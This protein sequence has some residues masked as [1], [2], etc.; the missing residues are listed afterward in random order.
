MPVPALPRGGATKPRG[1]GYIHASA[2]SL[3]GYAP[4]ALMSGRLHGRMR[5]WIRALIISR[6]KYAVRR[7]GAAV[8]ALVALP[9]LVLASSTP[10]L[11]VE[12][13]ATLRAAPPLAESNKTAD[14]LKRYQAAS[15]LTHR[16][17]M[18]G[19]AE[20][21]PL[22]VE[23]RHIGLLT[24]FAGSYSGAST[25][26]LEALALR[27]LAGDPEVALRLVVMLRRLRSPELFDALLV[28]LLAG[29][30]DCDALLV[31]AAGAELERGAA[32]VEPKLARLLPTLHPAFGHRV[33]KRLADSQYSA[34]EKPLLELLR[35]A[36][37]DGRI[38]VV[39]L[40]EQIVRFPSDAALNAVARKLIEIAALAEDKTPP[41]PG[42]QFSMRIEDIPQDGLLC[43][44]EMLR[45]PL[46]LGDARSR[47]VAELIRVLQLAYPEATLD[48]GL[49]GAEA[50]AKLSPAERKSFEAMLA[51]RV[52]IEALARDLTPENLVHWLLQRPD[53]RM[54]KRFIARGIDINRPT[55]L[56]LRPLVAAAQ[57]ID[58]EGVAL[59]LAAGADPNLANAEPDSEGN[60]ALMELSRHGASQNFLIEAGTRTMRL[61]LEHKADVQA[62]NRDGA[63]ALHFAASQ[64]P[65]LAT[66]LLAAGAPVAVAARNGSTP[67]HR[68][69]EGRQ[70]ELA[71]TLLDRGADVNAE[72]A[73]GVTP[74]LWAQ[75]NGDKELARLLAARGGRVNA[76][77]V[78]KRDAVRLLHSVPGMRQ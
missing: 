65:E 53:R 40:A 15:L 34:G 33:A 39:R 50:L 46:P 47:T 37:L 30:I 32:D 29:R 49:F 8:R 73:G 43:S 17:G 1:V 56:G 19:Q 51:E 9:W 74:L 62:R 16:L 45:I 48:R 10:A 13:A 14:S 55:R 24:A 75:D 2:G 41:K 71:K 7:A 60:T 23:M 18:Q 57:G 67:L 42:L 31:A 58:A 63:T 38:S 5:R 44:T 66:L 11:T 4:P 61:L 68:A 25:P 59:L 26:E 76:G 12:E 27:Y 54:L 22:L 20:A 77:Y 28:A 69:V 78:L 21:V 64:R 36:P 3:G 52:R 6:G 35:R 70:A 72:E